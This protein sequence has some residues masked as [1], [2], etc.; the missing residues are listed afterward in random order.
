MRYYTIT[1]ED[2]GQPF[3]RAFGRVWPVSAF[4][5]R[6]MTIDIGKRVYL[7]GGILQAENGEQR[8]ERIAHPCQALHNHNPTE[9][10]A[11]MAAPQCECPTGCG[12]VAVLPLYRVTAYVHETPMYE[13]E[14]TVFCE[15]CGN[16]AL[17]SGMYCAGDNRL[18]PHHGTDCI[19]RIWDAVEA[20]GQSCDSRCREYPMTPC[21]IHG[22][23][24]GQS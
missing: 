7:R 22:E 8:A 3:L 1:V 21:P 14:P 2:V 11:G 4:L 15:G 17:E 5:G 10:D 18:E 19:R 13:P 16:K 12:L 20:E 6:I 9:Y 23:E 24:G